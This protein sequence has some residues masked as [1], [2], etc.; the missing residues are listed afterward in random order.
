MALHCEHITNIR[1]HLPE[2]ARLLMGDQIVEGCAIKVSNTVEKTAQSEEEYKQNIAIAEIYGLT[3]EDL[4]S[5][6]LV[7]TPVGTKI[8][9]PQPFFIT[10]PGWEVCAPG[11]EVIHA[12]YGGEVR[13]FGPGADLLEGDLLVNGTVVDP[14][15]ASVEAPYLIPGVGYNVGPDG[16]VISP[17]ESDDA[18]GYCSLQELAGQGRADTKRVQDSI[19]P[20]LELDFEIPGL[21]MTW[22]VPIQEKIT[23][24]TS[25]HTKLATKVSGLKA[26]I[27]ADP[28][29]DAICKYMPQAEK[30]LAL[31]RDVQR[32]IIQIR[33]VV[34]VVRTAVATVKKIIDTIEAIF[35]IGKAVKLAFVYLLIKQMIMGLAQMIDA[36]ARSLLDA[37][38][39]L[40]QLVAMLAAMIQACANQRG[41]ESGL[42]KEDCE[43]LGGTWIDAG[44]RKGDVGPG[45]AGAGFGDK[46]IQNLIDDLNDDFDLYLRPGLVLN[47]GDEIKSGCVKGGDAVEVIAP[48]IFIIPET[49]HPWVVCESAASGT[50]DNAVI[51]ESEIQAVLNSQ[52]VDLSDCLTRID[53][54]ESTANFN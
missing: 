45:E 36:L 26:K 11:A 41:L 47:A 13:A 43:A 23:E 7:T 35:M 15:G 27:D 51:S 30:L 33:Q 38:R 29:P 3:E 40:P 16:A 14:N 50:S 39:V 22:W 53:E 6:P 54:I 44:K 9:A 4:S 1:R 5:D 25:L 12:G 37:N 46:D 17:T 10:E 18:S 21:D 19:F 49:N 2:G 8:Y 42:S 32:L 52:L 24:I 48:P 31:L 34:Q 28:D 20:D